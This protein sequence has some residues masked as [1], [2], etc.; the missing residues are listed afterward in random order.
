MSEALPVSPRPFAEILREQTRRWRQGEALLLEE[1]LKRL[2][3]PVTDRE[4]LLDLLCNE[5]NER[6]RA[7]P[8]PDLGEYRRRFPQYE[9]EL[10]IWFDADAAVEANLRAD[11]VDAQ[12]APPAPPDSGQIPG[13]LATVPPE[14]GKP[15]TQATQVPGTAHPGH[16]GRYRVE[17]LLGEG[18][19]GR[20]YLAHD[21]QLRRPVA[22]KV[23]HLT[24]VSQPGYAATYLAEARILASLD[25]AHIV[26]VFDFGQTDEGLPYVVSKFIE[27]SELARTI[28]HA[29][30]SFT[31][32]AELV[33]TVA[34]ALHYAH[35]KGLVHRDIKPGNLLL[36]TNGKPYVADFG[37]ALREEDFG[38]RA[39]YAGTPLYMSPEQARGEGHRVDGRSDV[40]SLGVVFYE[41]LTG[42]R[43]FQA[44]TRA[45]LL[46]Q[47][48]AVEPRPLRQ[49]DDA[50]PRELERIC[51]KALAKKATERYLTASDLAEDLR[52][53]LV[54]QHSPRAAPAP[55]LAPPAVHVN[56][57]P[58]PTGPASAFPPP[59]PS[60]SDSGQ[61]RPKVVPKGLRSFDA[62][63]ADFFLELLPGPRHRDGLPESIRFWKTRIEAT[64][65]EKTFRVGLLYGPSGCG[66]SSLVK[67]GLLPRLADSVL[68]LYV[69]AT[70]ADTEARLRKALHKRFQGWVDTR[71]LVEALA[72]LRR[73]PAS[74][75]NRAGARCQKVLLVLDQFEQWLHARKGEQDTELVQALR[76]CDGEHVQCLVLVRDDFGMAAARF[77]GELEIPILQG[78]NFTTV[79]LFDLRH[80]R[81]V[82]RE[83]GWAFGCLPDNP[84][85]LSPAHEQFLDQAV[86]GLAQDGKVISVR[87][88]L[89]AEMVKGK[90]WTPATLKEMG[91]IAG[92]GVTFL[93]ETL[94]A[95]AA[96]PEH[97]LHQ[98]AA[99][100][101]L[102][103]LLPEQGTDIKGHTRSRQEL[104][105][106]SG[107]ARRPQALDGLLRVLDTELRL[108]TPTDRV[109]SEEGGATSEEHE[110]IAGE[111][112][113][114]P[115]QYY[116][117][118]HDFLVPA[119]RQWLTRKQRETRRGR[120][121]LLLAERTA[122]WSAKQ[123]NRQLP[124]C[125]EWLNILL[126]TRKKD[127][128]VLQCE[129]L[130]AAT[131]KHFWQTGVLAV[132]FTLIGWALVE[133]K[134]GPLK[135][136]IRVRALESAETKDV[137][138]IVAELSSCSSWAKPQLKAMAESSSE[139]NKQARKQRLHANLALLALVPGEAEKPKDY[140]YKRLL[141]ADNPTEFRI[142]LTA[143][144]GDGVVEHYSEFVPKLWKLLPAE[145]DEDRHFRAACAL[146]NFVPDAPQW[147]E[148][149]RYEVAR[150]LVRQEFSLAVQWGRILRTIRK[151]LKRSLERILREPERSESERS[152][153]TRLLVSV[154]IGV[155]MNETNWEYL[156]DLV[157]ETEGKAYEDLLPNFLGVP[158]DEA[159]DLVNKILAQKL[160]END[161]DDLA[162][163]QAHAAVVLL[164]LD[165]GNE[166]L[167][168]LQQAAIL[169]P[170]LRQ[171]ADPRRRSYLIHRFGRVRVN[172][173]SFIR[174]YRA[175]KDDS[176]RRALLLSLG[177]FNAIQLPLPKRL[178]LMTKLLDEYRSNTDAAVHSAV[179]WLLSQWDQQGLL[180][181]IDKELAT[182][183]VEGERQW[184]INRQ[185][186]T[187]A[188]ITKKEVKFSMGSP[189]HE[190]D[191]LDGETQHQRHLPHPF[192]LA[193]KEVTVGQFREF[194]KDHPDKDTRWER[195]LAR[196]SLE[197]PIVSVT[198]FEA[199]AYCNWLSKQEGLPE[200]QWCYVPNEKRQYA[201][202]MKLAPNWRERSGYRLPTEAEW[203]YACRA[204]VALRRHFGTDDAMLGPYA[205]YG[206]NSD[207]HVHPVGTKMPND[208][209]LFDMYGNAAEWCQDA[210][211]PY[212][213]AAGKALIE[214]GGDQG[215]VGPTASRVLRG[216]AFVSSAAQLRSAYRF[217][218]QPHIPPYFAGLRVAKTCR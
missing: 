98:R 48:T 96:N 5:I 40:F 81:K 154:G 138:E 172:P 130:R 212:P 175:E 160:S 183:K 158:D 205:W 129:M 206:K 142:I 74:W 75:Q 186:Q 190:R 162:K 120:V 58:V 17:K 124:G 180:Q 119:L 78:Q 136:S 176:L 178:A 71:G 179:D 19:F 201:E 12:A 115:A 165:Q 13:P 118:T 170:M 1:F 64:D 185:R 207:D 139:D 37:L 182:G 194:L 103:A 107:Y 202:G 181:M 97:R 109:E 174:Q 108:I 44:E 145:T 70:V 153:A 173:E 38:K 204:G 187:M 128:T 135:A 195:S 147:E 125:W 82:L 10:A 152:V 72:S 211:A 2:P 146:A 14:E 121:E 99:G 200:D 189:E 53:W 155:S 16:I 122:L 126:F 49:V 198:W 34:G 60:G 67:A 33:A 50:I 149:L 150:W 166:D 79:D 59:A 210:F 47:I 77:L 184:Y 87:L 157:L 215:P 24:W 86:S 11:G 25:H 56:V 101:V 69:E 55:V 63:D 196:H 26:P 159:V 42:R 110:F 6:R 148:G 161:K 41:L 112:R 80:A 91:G 51:L 94:G 143:L 21:D 68:T 32:A 137:P 123:E 192:A 167:W 102:K 171:D 209:G 213:V 105:E 90:A 8:H 54:E 199:A 31:E 15:V 84:K 113:S 197:E 100:A 76:Q 62:E 18:S 61:V 83:F 156:R 116:Q 177:Q 141:E 36:D 104:L 30:P 27:G 92:L 131:R 73:H 7:G 35:R 127:W 66:K 188:V 28:K 20:V 65:P 144:H 133:V 3:V 193:T 4:Q 106:V 214:D 114:S 46:E 151:E 9:V 29:R 93:E 89:F 22:I 163:R 117:L 23:P 218:S 191:R 43:P 203:E 168:P 39:E 132:V 85:E 217:G 111:P 169:W 57:V 52:H 208:Y 88:A 140:L 216:G 95:R 134:Q 164:G 45:E